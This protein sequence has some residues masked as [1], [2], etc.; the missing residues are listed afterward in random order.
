[1]Q[2]DANKEEKVKE[3]SFMDSPT[4][5]HDDTIIGNAEENANGSNGTVKKRLKKMNIDDS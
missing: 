4:G 3:I 5:S 2:K 1:M